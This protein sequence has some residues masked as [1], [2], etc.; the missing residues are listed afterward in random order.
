LLADIRN[1]IDDK[2]IELFTPSVSTLWIN[3]FWFASLLI[4]LFSAIVG[5]LVKESLVHFI[6]T[7]VGQDSRHA[8]D[9]W[10]L[11][12]RVERWHLKELVIA[13]HLL[14]QFALFLFS[15]G[16]LLQ[17]MDD[18]S[19]LGYMVLTLVI[20]GI[21]I[22]LFLTMVSIFIPSSPFITPV[23]MFIQSFQTIKSHLSTPHQE[24][25]MFVGLSEIWKTL[26]TSQYPSYVDEAIAELARKKLKDRWW[27]KFVEW[28]VLKISLE[29]LQKFKTLGLQDKSHGY[30]VLCGHLNALLG[31]VSYLEKL[32]KKDDL[33]AG[34][35]NSLCEFLAPGNPLY[36][37]DVLPEEVRALAFTVRARIM[38]ANRGGPKL[39][40]FTNNEVDEQPWDAIVHNMP[41]GHRRKFLITACRA[42]NGSY[43]GLRKVCAFSMVICLAHGKL[44]VK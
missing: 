38:L 42:L 33:I 5:V 2:K 25:S 19:K 24:D 39:R 10:I 9:R 4:T 21:I 28:G 22:Y 37:W 36:R 13:V 29:R 17:S 40:D 31:F 30:E 7:T 1:T 23:T 20:S 44:A 34:L 6:P 26:V 15:L 27:K 32:Q 3:G 11:D 41:L 43:D 35:Q 18:N 14:I 16:F 12:R 8:Y